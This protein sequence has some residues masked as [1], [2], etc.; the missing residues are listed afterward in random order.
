MSLIFKM[1]SR[2]LCFCRVGRFWKFPPAISML[3]L[4]IFRL[5]GTHP[6][7]FH[8]FPQRTP[9]RRTGSVLQ[10][11][12]DGLGWERGITAQNLPSDKSDITVLMIMDHSAPQEISLWP[13]PLEALAHHSSSN[14]ASPSLDLP[15]ISLLFCFWTPCP[16]SMGCWK[17]KILLPRTSNT[18]YWE[19]Q[20]LLFHYH[21]SRLCWGWG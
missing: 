20:Y 11:F 19:V 6:Q 9:N 14:Q 15:H 21:S 4:N 10:I 8:Y 12:I 17:C 7:C 13:C 5:H 2:F 1:L 3:F 18:Q 16:F